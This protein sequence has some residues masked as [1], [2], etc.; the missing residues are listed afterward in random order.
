MNVC[1]QKFQIGLFWFIDSSI[2]DGRNLETF[3]ANASFNFKISKF[4]LNT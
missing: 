2:Y 3:S 1:F 4:N